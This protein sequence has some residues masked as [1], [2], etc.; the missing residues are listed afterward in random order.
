MADDHGLQRAEQ[1]NAP[2]HVAVPNNATIIDGL[3]PVIRVH[4]AVLN[5][6]NA[7]FSIFHITDSQNQFALTWKGQQWAFQVFPQSYLPTK[8][9]GMVA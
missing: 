1:D 9:H 2:I 3:A 7:F 6:A 5:L 8:C 4:H